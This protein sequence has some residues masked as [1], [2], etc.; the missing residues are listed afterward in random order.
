MNDAVAICS[1]NNL[2]FCIPVCAIFYLGAIVCPLNPLYSKGELKHALTIMKPKY[3]FISMIALNNMISIFKELHWFPR[4]L[5]L[6]SY[7]NIDVPWMSMYKAMSNVSDDSIDKFQAIHVDVNN[8]TTAILCS[9]GTTGLPKG[10]MWTDKNI[11][12]IIRMFISNTFLTNTMSLVLLPLFH[13]YS[14]TLLVIRLIGGSNSVVFSR[15]EEELFLQSIEK[16]KIEYL[17]VVPPIMV[18]LAKHPLVDKYDLSSIKRIWYV[19]ILETNYHRKNTLKEI[20]I[21]R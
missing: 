14:F 6:N 8:H 20:H 15:F 12:A 13:S 5:L 10:V 3:I 9:S 7:D 16:Y 1:E 2:E 18:F 21:K 4:V 11:I 17:M 19:E